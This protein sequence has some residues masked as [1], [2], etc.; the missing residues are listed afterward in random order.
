MALLAKYGTDGKKI[1]DELIS[2]RNTYGLTLKPGVYDKSACVFYSTGACRVFALILHQLSL[3]SEIKI[4]VRGDDLSIFNKDTYHYTEFTEDQ[5]AMIAHVFIEDNG[6]YIDVEGPIEPVA[7]I[8]SWTYRDDNGV[9]G[10]F[11]YK[12]LTCI[13]DTHELER[14]SP[15]LLCIT[16]SIVISFRQYFMA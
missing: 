12:I 2:I 10:R 14:F 5:R 4:L 15:E 8:D 13:T 9:D 1:K 11:N 16:E 6:M 3:D 7:L